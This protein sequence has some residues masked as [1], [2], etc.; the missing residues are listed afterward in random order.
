VHDLAPWLYP[1]TRTRS[2]LLFYRAAFPAS[3]RRATRIITD[4]EATRDDLCKQWPELEEKAVAVH[5]APTAHYK[6][7][8][9]QGIF[10]AAQLRLGLPELYI[11]SV[12]TL[13]PR[14]NYPLLLAAF[15]ALAGHEP[16]WDGI[17][18]V[19]VGKKGW[20]YDEVFAATRRLGLDERVVMADSLA[21]EEL[22]QL[23]VHCLA[24]VLPSFYEGFGLPVVEAMA[25]GAPVIIS[26]A[27]ALTEVAGGAALV[28]DPNQVP[29][30]VAALRVVAQDPQERERLRQRG[31]ERARSFS[32]ERAARETRRVYA[33]A[34]Q[35]WPRREV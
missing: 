23:Y 34:V 3:A 16:G 4:S 10:R 18:L 5:L 19:I 24:F 11:L 17:K 28:V 35:L 14:K 8:A 9:N 32:W 15:A 27:A 13:E 21:D 22:C 33:E 26:T 31:L 2:N 29:D 6:P 30:L 25:C 7:E 12:G 20:R 1:E